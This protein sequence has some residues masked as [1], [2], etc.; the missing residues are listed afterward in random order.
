MR[1][2]RHKFLQFEHWPSEDRHRWRAA[3]D[4]SDF[5]EAGRAARLSPATLKWRQRSYS[6]FLGFLAE[7][8]PEFI[9]LPARERCSAQVIAEYVAYYR[10]SCS[11]VTIFIMLD[12]L[13]Y[14]LAMVS[15]YHDWKWLRK[16]TYRIKR[17]ARPRRRPHITSERLYSLGIQIM[18]G[19]AAHA[20]STGFTS[21]CDAIM[22]R[23]GL[24]I[25]MLADIPLRSRTFAGLRIDRQLQRSGAL[26]CLNIT[27]DETKTRRPLE[28]EVAP[29]L[30]R[31]ISSYLN[32]FRPHITG[33][34]NHDGLWASMA[35]RPMA[36]GTILQN[37]SA[38]T[39]EAFGFA[40]S[41]HGFRRA[42]ATFWSERDPI[43]VRGAKDVLGHASFRMTETHYIKARSRSAGRALANTLALLKTRGP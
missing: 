12:S 19:A 27:A 26:W 4:S 28:Y 1:R 34:R 40:V 20:T 10:K 39:H 14:A 32:D 18:E 17:K 8:Y 35:G 31:Y 13:R 5:L 43:N 36:A 22:Y 9:S 7:R 11:D 15:P 29:S 37:V 21:W 16:I 3:L 33:S 23:D 25:A 38:H 24:Q 42:A 6:L 41:L 2:S 30:T